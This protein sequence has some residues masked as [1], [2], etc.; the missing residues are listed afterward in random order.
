LSDG[1]RI[2]I[3]R[4]SLASREPATRRQAFGHLRDACPEAGELQAL[5]VT[6]PSVAAKG[7]NSAERLVRLA[8]DANPFVR[9]AAVWNL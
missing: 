1:K 5:L 7:V 2:A 9:A 3:L 6:A 4:P 8:G